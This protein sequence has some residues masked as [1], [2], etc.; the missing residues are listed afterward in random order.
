LIDRKRAIASNLPENPH[1]MRAG[2]LRS[3][4]LR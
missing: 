3:C 1:E 2:R 4:A